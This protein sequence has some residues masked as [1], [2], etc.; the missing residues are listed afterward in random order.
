MRI[1]YRADKVAEKDN[2]YA[3]MTDGAEIRIWFVNDDILRIRAGFDG[4][5][6]ED[7][8]SL[9]M[10]AWPSL[11]DDVLKEERKRVETA[12]AVLTDHKEE[13]VIQG[14]H[15]RVVV[16]KHPFR[17][18]VYDTDHTL[19]H[20]DIPDLAYREDTNRRRKHTG[21]IEEDDRFY[22]FGE[23]GGN[24]DKAEEVL[25]MAPG[26]A[27]GYNA[28]KTDSLYKHIP[29]YIRLQGST[30]KAVG[31]FYHNTAECM[32]NMGR[33]KRNYW[34][35][36]STYTTDAGDI[37]LFLINGPAIKDVIM[38]YTDLTGKSAM[39]PRGALGYLGSSMY[40]PELPEDCDDAILEFI[41]TAKEEGIPIDGFQ[42][43]SGYC[44]IETEAGIKRC[45][46]TWNHKRFK[47]PADWFHQMQERGIAV[48]ANI[49]PGM[50]TVHP[51]LEEM[52]AKGMFIKADPAL[53]ERSDGRYEEYAQ[54]TWWG[55]KGLFVDF[56]SPKARECW[57]QYIKDSLLKYGC[58]SIW[59]D[60]CEYDSLVDLDAEV[61]LEGKGSTIGKSKAV[62]ANLMCMLSN[63]AMKEYDPGRRPF[64]VCRSGHAGI[65][66]YAQ[67]WAGDNLT[68]WDTLKYNIA[69]ILGMGL[70]GVA[71]MGCDIGGFYGVSPEPEL[72]V[73]WVQNGIFF[74][75][76][77]IHSTN[78]DNTVTEPWMYSGYKHL[79]K[80]A[81]AFRY[82]M[83]PYLYSLEYRAHETGLPI[84][85]P[86]FL[87]H[88]HDPDTYAQGIDF[89]WGEY[90][91]VANVVEKGQ[92][93][94]HV[95]LPK[96]MDE[97][98]RWYDWQ[99]RQEYAAGTDI[100]VSVDLS[101]VPMFVRSGAI[102]PMSLRPLNNLATETVTDLKILF[103]PDVDSS[104]TMYEDDGIS[105]DYLTGGY[106]KTKIDVAAGE[107]TR[108]R[109]MHEG[110]YQT[111]VERLL[112]D[113]IHREKAPYYVLL[114]GR[115]VKHYL[116]RRKFEEAEEG[117]YYSQT[118]KSV[119]VKYANPKADHEVLISFENF[120]M[121][122]M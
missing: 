10:T 94:R 63:E 68:G 30:G 120:D 66:R 113:V 32:F 27:M 80:D 61:C 56:T 17:L 15:L 103:A 92:T 102:V 111:A 55:G 84:M 40:Y 43:S 69:T 7:S 87:F 108:I 112:L 91:L 101:S 28:E 78:T 74:P 106:L 8:Y 67:V 33:E 26:D 104:F 122:G 77:S 110:S 18:A 47:D 48:S 24:I 98:E 70:S 34:H 75:R 96:C 72:F 100:D 82:A 76:F 52:K 12:E 53:D 62:M 21:R 16:H 39:L 118:L 105:N 37:D 93:A 71:N 85:A 86:L 64:S 54:G 29:F 58:T 83:I 65:Q 25:F 36:Y 117:W 31:Y 5:F 23:K 49:K 3:V 9:V 119:Q 95:Y 46:F 11:T 89:L 73:R 121:I 44:A 79:I 97:R 57:K 14:N 1:C 22:G 20:E 41:D 4:D 38:R 51:L 81:I 13:A 35:R 60:N 42:L 116:H 45:T 2:Y 107:Q 19:L 90:V 50:L 59:N 114:D 115:E 99:T 109:F 88:Q 6:A